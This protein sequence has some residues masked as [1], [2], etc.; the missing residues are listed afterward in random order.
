MSTNALLDAL[1]AEYDQ[2]SPEQKARV[3]RD[4]TR[5]AQACKVTMAQLEIGFKRL[6]ETFG[7]AAPPASGKR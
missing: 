5:A 7:A 3:A 4:F 6:Q 2:L 1:L